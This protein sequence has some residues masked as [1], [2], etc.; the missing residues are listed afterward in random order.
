MCDY[1]A[2]PLIFVR[3]L[4]SS[5]Q[6]YKTTYFISQING[7]GFSFK[8]LNI[9][10]KIVPSGT[11]CVVKKPLFK[12]TWKLHLIKLGDLCLKN[13]EMI[14]KSIDQLDRSYRIKRPKDI[15]EDNNWSYSC[16]GWMPQLF[17]LNRSNFAVDR[18]VKNQTII[19]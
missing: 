14:L 17:C 19:P 2:S 15:H 12:E 18:P 3:M 6:L 13:N 5:N 16:E 10:S 9:G 8:A 4:L 1:L 7:T 11:L